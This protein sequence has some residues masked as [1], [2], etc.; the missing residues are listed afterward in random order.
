[1]LCS[2][3]HVIQILQKH[4]LDHRNHRGGPEY[5]GNTQMCKLAFNLLVF[6]AH[7]K[8]DG[9]NSVLADNVKC[10]HEVYWFFTPLQNSMPDVH[11]RWFDI[12]TDISRGPR[13]SQKNW[14]TKTQLACRHKTFKTGREGENHLMS[15]WRQSCRETQWQSCGGGRSIS[16]NI[17]KVC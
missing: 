17:M 1:M 4:D 8:P 15:P 12:H 16:Q 11:Q 5:E 9:W 3:I 2:A 10:I 14:E 13:E 7:W 6:Y